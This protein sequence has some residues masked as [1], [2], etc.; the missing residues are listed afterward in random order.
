MAIEPDFIKS[1]NGQIS[2]FIQAYFLL[3]IRRTSFMQ[4]LVNAAILQRFALATEL[5]ATFYNLAKNV[6]F[7]QKYDL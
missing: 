4:N 6:A 5:D 2:S 3:Q 7:F 1:Q